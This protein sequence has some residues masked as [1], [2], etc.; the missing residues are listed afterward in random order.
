MSRY[1][2]ESIRLSG[3]DAI[4][5]ANSLFRPTN[6]I[7]ERNQR[8]MHDIS[9]NIKVQECAYG[10]D[11][12]VADLDLSFLDDISREINVEVTFRIRELGI[13][14]CNENIEKHYTTVTMKKSHEYSETQNDNFT[15][16][17]A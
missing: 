8:I 13:V 7:L 12:E 6:E 15:G 3:M 5:F 14:D 11:A 9:E 10:F 17:A 4:D 2:I 1:S 16:I